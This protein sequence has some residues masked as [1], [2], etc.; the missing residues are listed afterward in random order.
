MLSG[1][2]VAATLD[3]VRAFVERLSKLLYDL[4]RRGEAA[5]RARGEAAFEEVVDDYLVIEMG[6]RSGVPVGA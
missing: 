4:A 5:V 6:A 1:G 3:D 2:G